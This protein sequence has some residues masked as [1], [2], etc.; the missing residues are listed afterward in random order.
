MKQTGIQWDAWLELGVEPAIEHAAG[1][2][3]GV[4]WIPTLQDPATQTRSYART[5]YFD[6]VADRTNLHLLTGYRVNRV[7]FS[8]DNHA[9]SVVFQQ[10]GTPDGQGE[11]TVNAGTEIVLSAGWLHTPQILQ[12]SG[13]GPAALLNEAGIDILVENSGVGANLQDHTATSISYQCK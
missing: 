8:E 10:R 13:I 7:L 9:E 6:P 12:R 5:G 2:A 1:Q 11:I 3:Y 4:F